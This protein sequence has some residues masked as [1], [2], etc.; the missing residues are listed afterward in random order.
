VFSPDSKKI[1]SAGM[2]DSTFRI[3]DVEK[4]TELYVGK[5]AHENWVVDVQ[6]SPDGKQVLTAGRDMKL[7]L[8][9]AATG[10]LEK[11]FEG[12]KDEPEAAAFSKDGKRIVA[13]DGK[14]VVIFDVNSGKII[15]RFDEHSDQVL[16]VAFM[17]DGKKALSA[18]KDNTVRLWSI[19]K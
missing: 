9:N 5:D 19:P 2:N 8:W 12:F 16:A 1:A 14:S 15:H 11:T 7:K 17:P 10:K 18:G 13:A 6:F 4:G 3:W